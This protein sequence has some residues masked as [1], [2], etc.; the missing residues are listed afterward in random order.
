MTVQH[1]WDRLIG[2][3]RDME[4]VLIAYSGGVDSSL[5]LKAAVEV[6][7]QNVIAVTADSETYPSG[8]LAEAKEFTD[9]LGVRHHVLYTDELSSEQFA[10]NTPDRCYFC[11]KE[12]Y[13]RLRLLA[14]REGV[15]WILDGS[16]VDDLRDYRPGS[17]AASEF[18]VRSPLREAG[19]TKQD[20]RD[21]ARVLNLPVWDKP[22]LACLSS[23]IPYGTS[24][25]PAVLKMVQAAEDYLRVLGLNQVRVR[26]YG[27]TARI[28]IDRNDFSMLLEKGV[29][30]RI[31]SDLKKLGY[32]YVCLDLEGYRTGSMNESLLKVRTEKK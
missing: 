2:L 26:H 20:V 19:F 8:E 11:K 9:S 21:C 13:G 29:P 3:L 4:R 14:E 24:I 32:T 22:S 23:R 25:T 10:A 12:L 5:L 28:E 31:V 15:S 17:R 1:K 16:N 18:G 7:G 30:G 27:D 6:L